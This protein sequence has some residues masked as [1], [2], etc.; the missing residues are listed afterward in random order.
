[1]RLKRPT[2]LKDTFEEIATLTINRHYIS[3]YTC[4]GREAE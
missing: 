3:I 4:L 2:A 1:M